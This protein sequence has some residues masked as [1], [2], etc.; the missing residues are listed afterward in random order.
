MVLIGILFLVGFGAARLPFLIGIGRYY[1]GVFYVLNPYAYVRL[2]SGQWGLLLGY[3]LTPFAIKA[4]IELLEQ[5]SAKNGV[6]LALLTTLVALSQIHALFLLALAC[7]IFLIVLSVKRRVSVDYRSL[8]TAL[9]VALGVF[10]AFNLYWLVPTVMDLGAQETIVKRLGEGDSTLYSTRAISSLGL[11]FDVASLHGF[12][13]SWY[14]YTRNFLPVWWLPFLL[15]FFL[16]VYGFVAHVRS[17]S[18][19]RLVLALGIMGVF[20]FVLALGVATPGNRLL[21]GSLWSEIPGA[22]VFR[23][24]HK[25]A[26]LLALS[27]AYLG[28]LGLQGVVR[29]PVLRLSHWREE[30]WK[31]LLLGAP[32]LPLLYTFPMV[33]LADQVRPTEFPNE[34]Y[35]VRDVLNDDKEDYNVLFLPWHMYMPYDWL[36]TQEKNLANPAPDFFGSNVIAGDNIEFGLSTQSVS[37]VSRYVEFLL[38]HAKEIDNLG[39]L[40]APLNVRY[41]LLAKESDYENCNFLDKQPEL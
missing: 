7:L 31:V 41:V 27:Y 32:I 8:S 11:S 15:M 16:A 22:Q 30:G 25:F 23:D 1:A 37:P 13:R 4:F 39:E 40:L 14:L 38:S 20:S 6:R 3:A 35:Q 28:A 5:R 12:W 21:L 29:M 34:W 17:K 18:F 26:A 10:V 33:G 2:L 36:P 9:G 24:S 19:G